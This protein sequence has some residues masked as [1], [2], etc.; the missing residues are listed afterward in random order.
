MED[1]ESKCPAPSEMEGEQNNKE[2]ERLI[3]RKRKRKG[4][5][6]R[7]VICNGK[8]PVSESSHQRPTEYSSNQGGSDINRSVENLL[9]CSMIVCPG[10]DIIEK[11]TSFCES[12]SCNAYI[13][14]AVGSVA[15]ANILQCDNAAMYEGSFIIV[16]LAGNVSVPLNPG[17]SNGH[18]KVSVTLAGNNGNVF[19]GYVS[20]PLLAAT[21]VQ[22]IM[23]KL[24]TRADSRENS[25]QGSSATVESP[26]TASK[27]P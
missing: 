26:G 10:E 27:S 22:I 11:I 20:G 18:Y 23:W 8:V 19:G 14:S 5:P 15:R 12:Y 1:R 7:L 3:S 2:N 24:P 4:T 21:N 13:A 25:A 6:R 16:T 9:P 17:D